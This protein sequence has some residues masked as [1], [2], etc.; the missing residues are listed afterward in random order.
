VCFCAGCAFV[1]DTVTLDNSILGFWWRGGGPSS[2]TYGGVIA[3]T[4]VRSAMLT[5]TEGM[6]WLLG[7]PSSYGYSI[8]YFTKGERACFSFSYKIDPLRSLFKFNLEIFTSNTTTIIVHLP[9][10]IEDVGTSQGN[11]GVEVGYPTF[12]EAQQI[13]G[14][15]GSIE[16]G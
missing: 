4:R 9:E 10:T 6:I 12:H 11:E 5:G 2:V 14:V 15:R 1:R 3:L 7:S 8:R 16:R 13:R